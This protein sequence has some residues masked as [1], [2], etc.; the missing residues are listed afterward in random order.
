MNT[1]NGNAVVSATAPSTSAAAIGTNAQPPT[2]ITPQE[3]IEQLLAVLNENI[4]GRD[5]RKKQL[6]KVC[7]YNSYFLPFYMA[8]TACRTFMNLMKN[9]HRRSRALA[10]S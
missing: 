6:L 3:Q 10:A 2:V 8:L 4:S 7:I 9:M 5:D 1:A